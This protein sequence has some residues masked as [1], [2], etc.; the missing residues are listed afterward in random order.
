M[1]RVLICWVMNRRDSMVKIPPFF[2]TTA[3]IGGGLGWAAMSFSALSDIQVC[4]LPALLQSIHPPFRHLSAFSIP[5]LRR[6]H[7]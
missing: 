4:C 3:G 5:L 7:A 1:L 6:S 2:G